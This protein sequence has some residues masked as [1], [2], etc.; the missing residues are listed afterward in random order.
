MFLNNE[1]LFVCP[2]IPEGFPITL[3]ISFSIPE[4]PPHTIQFFSNSMLA[5]HFF[6][7]RITQF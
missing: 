1:G 7:E 4:N 2:D 6:L 3:N 5:V